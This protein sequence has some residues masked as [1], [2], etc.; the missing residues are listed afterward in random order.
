LKN[1]T[2]FLAVL[3][4]VLAIPASASTVTIQFNSAPQSYGGYGVGIYQGTVNGANALFVCDDFYTDISGGSTW[5]ADVNSTDPVSSDVLFTGAN[6]FFPFPIGGSLTQQQDYNM[7]GYLAN[8]IFAD[9]TNASGQWGYESFALW[10]LN[11]S[12]AWTSAV[13]GGFSND[14]LPYLHDA[15]NARNTLTNDVVYTPVP[16]NAGQEFVSQ[17]PEPPGF[18]LVLTGIGLVGLSYWRRRKMQLQQ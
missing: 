17:T 10:T 6:V 7:I 18:T 9:P 5:Q 4:L 15:Y 2:L 3:V 16:G 1:A 11:D 8:R 14:V 12:A 13:N